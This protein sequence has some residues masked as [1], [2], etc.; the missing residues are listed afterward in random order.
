L[1]ASV[2]VL[3]RYIFPKFTLCH[4]EF[5]SLKLRVPC[6]TLSYIEAN[7]GTNWFQP[8]KSWDWKKSASNVHENG[9][10]PEEERHQVIQQFS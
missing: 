3:S 6:E 10:W 2:Y 7:Y 8:V 5:L 1:Q 9:E 4:T